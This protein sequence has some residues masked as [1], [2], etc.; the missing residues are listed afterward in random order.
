ELDRA[1][2]GLDRVLLLALVLA[3]PAD[4]EL[5]RL[6]DLGLPLRARVLLERLG[7]LD[8]LVE[9]LERREAADEVDPALDAALGRERLLA[10]LLDEAL[11][12][13]G[14]L[15]P[16]L[17]L[18]PEGDELVERVEVVGRLVDRGLEL[19]ELL[20]GAGRLLE[21]RVELLREVFL[22]DEL[23]RAV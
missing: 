22:R 5:G 6:H 21:E 13:R 2:V 10:R 4:E 14:R 16:V 3:R 7:V 23:L 17:V 11:E 8:A 15:G 12:E 20:V 9:A 1:V 18:E 19:R